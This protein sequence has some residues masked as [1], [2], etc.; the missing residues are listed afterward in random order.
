MSPIGHEEPARVADERTRRDLANPPTREERTDHALEPAVDQDFVELEQVWAEPRGFYGWFTHVNHKSIGRRYIFTAFVFFGLAGVLA[1]LMR[2]QLSRP[3]NTFLSADLYN[4]IF[5]MHGSTMMFLFA[6]PVMEAVG[7]Y[8]VP[9]MVGARQIAF[10]RLNAYSY[11]MYLFGG[12]FLFGMFLVN[13]GPDVGWFAYV[14][15]AGPEYTPGKR[16]DVWA[17]LITFTEVAALAVSVEII[18]TVFK[19]RAPGMSL[20]RIPIFVWGQVVTA[21]MVLFAMPAVMLSSTMLILDRLVGTHFF[22]PAEGG[23]A[24]LWQHLFWFF[25]HPEVYIIFIPATGMMSTIIATFSRRHMFGYL[26]VVLALVTTAFMGFGLWVHHMFTTGLPQLGANFFTGAS[27]I[28]AIPTGIQVFCWIA[29]MWGGR[30]WVRSPML[31]VLGFF[32]VFIIGGLTGVMLAAVPLDWQ[33]HDTFFVVAHF[34]Y[35][36]IG[37]AVFPL[38]GAIYYWYP[39][40][41]GRLMNERLAALHFW[42]FFVG[43]NLTFFPMHQLGMQGMPRRIYTYPPETGWGFLNAVASSGAVL[44]AAAVLLFFYN[45]WVSRFRGEEAG[46]NP[47]DA[48]TLE[49]AT[50]S[51]P[52]NCNF[53]YPPTVAGREPLW[54][55]PADQPVVVGLRNDVRDVL[56]THVHDATPD[57]RTE[58]PAP[59]IWPFLT[60][61][62]TTGLFVGSIFTPWAIVYGAVPLFVTLTGWFWPKKPGETGTQSWP[63]AQRT[64]PLPHEAPGEEAA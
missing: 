30:V 11:W 25:G 16:A 32:G 24:L 18:V 15:L 10:P 9:L 40:I 13:T 50:S 44:M 47:W 14:P 7:I 49:W 62:A 53:V 33:V 43:F 52:P 37:G 2:L 54:D 35:V 29:T 51:P 45:A 3:N 55:N 20:N 21:F 58:F 59:S 28:I 12:I 63:I 27:I 41:T 19:M 1:A 26:A 23:D 61:V 17:Q 56:V 39:K 42:L 8:V 48:G 57:H 46:D 31:W 60:A 38:F 5:T 6:V 64:L 36:L 22:N 4:Q 34:H